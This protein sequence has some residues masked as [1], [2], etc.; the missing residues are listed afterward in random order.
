MNPTVS[1]IVTVYNRFELTKRAVESVLAQTFPVSEVILMDDGSFDGT[2]ELLPPYIAENPTWRQRVRYSHQDNQGPGAARNNGIALATGEW[3]AFIDNDDLWLPQKLEWQFRALDQF[4]KHCG[5]CISDAWFMNNPQMKMTL[6]QLAG[7]QHSE[8]IG[9]ITD[10]LKYMLETNSVVGIHPV[11]L[12]NLITRTELAREVGGFD[13]KLRFGDDDD[14]V[15]RLGCETKF[16]FVN[17][18]MVLIDRT[19]PT[20]RHVGEN[21]RWDDD[22]FRLQMAQS[23]LEKRLQLKY[24]F[25]EEIRNT[26]RQHLAAVHSGWANWFLENEEYGKASK[27]LA[28]AAK[29]CLTRNIAIKRALCRWTPAIARKLASMRAEYRKRG[30]VGIG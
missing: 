17:M 7:K 19:S 14:F 16:C 23:R 4:E 9:M 8:T 28:E 10:P 21:K 1:V 25:P 15:F 2:S 5:A 20:Q 26:I 13:P 22:D 24:D 29:V 11:W 12:Q 18:P 3:L 6:F 30:Y 27:S